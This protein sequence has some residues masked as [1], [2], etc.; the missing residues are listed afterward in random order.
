MMNRFMIFTMAMFVVFVMADIALNIEDIEATNE[1]KAMEMELVQSQTQDEVYMI[2]SEP[3]SRKEITVR[4]VESFDAANYLDDT[5]LPEE[6][7]EYCMEAGNRYGIDGYLLMAMVERESD[8]EADASNAEGDS[9]LLQVNPKWHTERM[10]RLG[11][12]DLTDP[13]SN[14]LVAADY[15]HELLEQNNYNL[16]L[17]LMKYNMNHQR[18]EELISQGIYSD[19]ASSV[20][21]RSYEL[22]FL[23]EGGE[24]DDE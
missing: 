9:G 18:A 3:D 19:Y 1:L 6:Y 21:K 4:Y 20:I 2:K 16:P 15:L 17:A 13:G 12:S 8:G 5:D 23:K 14:I 24:A 22:R 10:A 7:Q 11:V